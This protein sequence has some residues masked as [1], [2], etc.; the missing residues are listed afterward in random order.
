MWFWEL[1]RAEGL[2]ATRVRANADDATF[3]HLVHWVNHMGWP[4]RGTG[5]RFYFY[6]QPT[7]GVYPDESEWNSFFSVGD[8]VVFSTTSTGM[9]RTRSADLHETVS[10]LT[11]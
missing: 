9:Y 4:H 8:S 3:S 7:D 11:R 5:C 2:A 1:T 10:V 6:I